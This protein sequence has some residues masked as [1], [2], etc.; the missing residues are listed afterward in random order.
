MKNY[1]YIDKDIKYKYYFYV[2]L[3]KECIERRILQLRI[4]Y[5]KV[6]AIFDVL[7]KMKYSKTKRIV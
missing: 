5:W 4:L 3:F 2:K 7:G 6:R 1:W